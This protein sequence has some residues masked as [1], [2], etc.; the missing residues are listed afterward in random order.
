[1][2]EL[3]LELGPENDGIKTSLLHTHKVPF[4]SATAA[5]LKLEDD[6]LEF[7]KVRGENVLA[8][9]RPGAHIGP[10]KL[11]HFNWP[12]EEGKKKIIC[13][14]RHEVHTE[15]RCPKLELDKCYWNHAKRQESTSSVIDKLGDLTNRSLWIF[16]NLY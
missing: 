13:F 12:N 10:Y 8:T 15:P 1:M 2:H 4:M 6:R 11:P 3:I 16:F 7:S 14:H 5:E 9:S